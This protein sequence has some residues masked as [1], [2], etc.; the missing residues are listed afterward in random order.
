MMITK[1]SI[2]LI[3][4]SF[5][6]FIFI[7]EDTIAKKQEDK[8]PPNADNIWSASQ[9][10]DIPYIKTLL[11]IYPDQVNYQDKDGRTALHY[12]VVGG[13]KELL[14]ILVDDFGALANLTDKNGDSILHYACTVG[15][16]EIALNILKKG[17]INHSIRN[18]DG[19]TPLHFSAMGGF[20]S[21]II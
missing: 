12:A 9:K 2:D 17:L 7:F 5:L 3:I 21:V 10:G 14:S 6:V 1:T 4:F 18:N 20:G 15:Q 16:K 19:L 8:P 11:K 13:H